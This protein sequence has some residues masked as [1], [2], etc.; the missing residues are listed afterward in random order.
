MYF[1][2]IFGTKVLKYG[3]YI[4]NWL[5]IKGNIMHY[6]SIVKNLTTAYCRFCEL[7]E[8]HHP[9]DLLTLEEFLTLRKQ[10]VSKPAEPLT[11]ASSTDDDDTADAA[12]AA[13]EDLTDEPPPGI[14]DQPSSDMSSGN[15]SKVYMLFKLF[16]LILANIHNVLDMT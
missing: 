4:G 2:V 1:R 8:Q 10:V 16:H 11:V 7:A 15:K 3:I 13:A 9:K 12:A 6:N 5:L 14:D